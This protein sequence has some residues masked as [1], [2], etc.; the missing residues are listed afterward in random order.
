MFTGPRLDN[1]KTPEKQGAHW[2]MTLGVEHV[3]Q[4]WKNAQET[5]TTLCPTYLPTYLPTFLPTCLPTYLAV[6][7]LPTAVLA[8]H[9]SVSLPRPLRRGPCQL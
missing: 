9:L 3:Y 5:A 2:D 8:Q 6:D 1:K 4:L 7:L